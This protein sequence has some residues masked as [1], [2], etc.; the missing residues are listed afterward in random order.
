MDTWLSNRST[1]DRARSGPELPIAVESRLKRGETLERMLEEVSSDVELRPLLTSIVREACEL[2]GADDGTIG[3]WDERRGVLRI[4]AAHQMPEGEV[5][6]DV[7]PGQGLAGRVLIERRPVVLNRY[8]EV[9]QPT[10]HRLMENAVIGLPIFWREQLVGFFGI[11]ARPPRRFDSGDVESLEIF[12]RHAAIGIEIARRLRREQSR[13]ERLELLARVGRT[14]AGGLELDELLKNAAS[15]IHSLLG[16]P[17]VAIPLLDPNDAQTLVLSVVAGS[18]QTR[19]AGEHRLPIWKGIM[20]AEV[21]EG[22][23]QLVNDVE[24]DP[25]YLPIPGARGIRAELAVPIRLGAQ[26]L[27]VLN[28]ESGEPFTAED[29]LLLEIAADHLAVAIKNARLFEQAQQLAVLEVRQRLARDLHDS[30]TQMLASATMI[31]QSVP[32]AFKRDPEEG[33]RRLE[34]MIQLNR[35]ALAEMRALLKELR[36]ASTTAVSPFSSAELPMPGILRV[37]RDGLASVLPEELA[38]LENDGFICKL[39]L[40][41]YQRLAPEREE[42]L[43]R[44]FQEAL[45]NVVKHSG[46]RHFE[47]SLTTHDGWTTMRIEDDGRGIHSSQSPA[48]TQAGTTQNGG[49]GLSTMRERAEALGGK[50]RLSSP[51]G[52]GTVLEVVVPALAR[53]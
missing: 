7:V 41:D 47:V 9:G 6:T 1:L 11:G 2:L 13:T 42:L 33:E 24:A 40:L 48:T 25:R 32:P 44:I 36:P 49:M 53:N 30:V 21:Q 18:V 35:S 51:K 46:A 31:A 50:L 12:A 14:I 37:R 16:Y 8:G 4:E 27:G 39:R 22:R 19:L 17:A 34:R 23:T 5:G 43:Y 26:I 52:S 45:S 15:S 38:P 20:G 3:I 28:V 10:Q 29:A